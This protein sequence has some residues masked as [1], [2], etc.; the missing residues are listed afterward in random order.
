MHQTRQKRITEDCH[1]HSYRICSHGQFRDKQVCR[2]EHVVSKQA[3][4]SG[5]AHF[6]DQCIRTFPAGPHEWDLRLYLAAIHSQG[7]KWL[8][9]GCLPVMPEEGLVF[10]THRTRQW[11]GRG[12]REEE[13]NTWALADMR[14]ISRASLPESSPAHRCANAMDCLGCPRQ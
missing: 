9:V 8:G 4:I 14:T 7:K 10:T 2:S 1:S 5:P 13:S 12:S 11:E 3:R 6:S